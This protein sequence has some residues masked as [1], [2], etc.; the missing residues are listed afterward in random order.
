MKTSVVRLSIAALVVAWCAAVSTVPAVMAEDSGVQLKEVVVTATKTEKEPQDVTQ[1]VTVITADDIQK[2]GATTA[3]DVIERTA[4][5]QVN[6]N[7]ALGSTNSINIRGSNYEQ[8]L[9]LLDGRRLNSASAGGFDMANLPVALEDID[10]PFEHG[11]VHDGLLP[12][13]VLGL[14]EVVA[15]LLGGLTGE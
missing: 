7:G 10:S 6:S 4:G 9:V 14:L 3:A 8:V 1:S 5:V 15:H 11:V 2:S 12:L 13:H